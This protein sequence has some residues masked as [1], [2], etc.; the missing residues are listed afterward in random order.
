MN[1]PILPRSIH[2]SEDGRLVEVQRTQD[3]MVEFAPRGGGFI[4]RASEEDFRAHFKPATPRGY[5]LVMMSGDFVPEGVTLP[6]YA[7]EDRWNGWAMPSFTFETAQSILEF[8]PDG[9]Y[10]PDIDAFAFMVNDEEEIY[11]AT[12]IEVDG[13]AV[14]VY[15]IG[16][17]SWVWEVSRESPPQEAER[18][19]G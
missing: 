10:R 7:N 16:A 12:T 15:P 5:S 14:K 18:P 6:A 8:L 3:G 13:K 11:E 9:Q 1:E 4:H 19:K 2:R 17:G